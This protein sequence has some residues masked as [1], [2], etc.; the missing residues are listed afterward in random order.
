[1]TTTTQ[2]RGIVS[3]SPKC[4][5][6]YSHLK[7]RGDHRLTCHNGCKNSNNQARVERAWWHGV[8]ERIGVGALVLADVGSLTNVLHTIQRP[9]GRQSF[10]VGDSLPLAKGT[11]M[12]S[13]TTRVE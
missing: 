1:M 11:E 12:Q 6:G 4:W 2:E 9:K 5:I 13:I 10:P 3:L 7:S 8:E